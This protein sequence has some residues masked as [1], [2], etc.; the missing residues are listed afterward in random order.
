MSELHFP[1]NMFGLVNATLLQLNTAVDSGVAEVT[2]A[3]LQTPCLALNDVDEAGAFQYQTQLSEAKAAS[4]VDLTLKR[5][6]VP[7][8]PMCILLTLHF[9]QRSARPIKPL[10]RMHDMPKQSLQS[11]R[12]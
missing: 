2:L 9:R 4:G 6:Q 8:P 3:L 5:V 10:R 12:Y 1:S 11:T 7:L